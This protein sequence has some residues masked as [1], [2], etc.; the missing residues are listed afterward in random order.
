MTS[1]RKFLAS[2]VAAGGVAFC[3]CGMLNAARAQG[4]AGPRPAV[5]VNGRRVKTIDVH[6]HC[7]FREVIPLLGSDAGLVNRAVRGAEEG[8]IEVEK[9]FAAMDSQKVDME[10]LSVNPFWYGRERDLAAQVVKLNNEKMAELC[11]A[12]PE[13]FA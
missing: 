2:A 1:R 9:R 3:T 4:A 8:F 12:H 10:V 5:M 11:A 7:V 13:R 6:A